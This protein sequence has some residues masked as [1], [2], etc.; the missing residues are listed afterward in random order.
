[1]K[2]KIFYVA[3]GALFFALCGSAGNKTLTNWG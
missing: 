3:L 1:M 2:K